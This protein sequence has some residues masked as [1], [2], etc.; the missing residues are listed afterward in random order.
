ML[1]RYVPSPPRRAVRKARSSVSVD[2]EDEGIQTRR[3]SSRLST[4]GTTHSSGSPESPA[5][6]RTKKGTRSGAK[7]KR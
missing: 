4:T 7:K 5:A 2:A 1:L 3:R 6:V